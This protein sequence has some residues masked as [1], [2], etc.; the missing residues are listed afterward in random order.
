MLQGKGEH[1]DMCPGKSRASHR[2]TPPHWGFSKRVSGWIP[3]GSSHKK[4]FS[5][6][7]TG[8]EEDKARLFQCV[9]W[10]GGR[11][12]YAGDKE[13]PFP[14]GMNPVVHVLRKETHL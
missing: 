14:N 6:C 9:C 3:P 4:G 5:R 13:I 8:W 12:A 11:L 7:R 2:S 10:G 1:K